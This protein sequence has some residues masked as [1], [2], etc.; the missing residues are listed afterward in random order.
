M[1]ALTMEINRCSVTLYEGTAAV[2]AHAGNSWSI[3]KWISERLSEFGKIPVSGYHRLIA[4]RNREKD[5]A[6]ENQGGP[7]NIR[8][9][10]AGM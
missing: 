5:A 3:E 1:S 9:T 10:A 8:L 7:A 4:L 6:A 2:G